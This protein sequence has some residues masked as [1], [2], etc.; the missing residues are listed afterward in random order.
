MSWTVAEIRELREGGYIVVDD[1]PCKI[2]SIQM[3]KPGKHGE[4][5]ARMDVMGLF[6]SRKRSI[7]H[8]V[9]HKVQVPMIDKRKGQIISISGDHAQIM[10]AENYSMMEL[11]LDEEWKPKV[12]A[13]Q[14]CMYM[15]VLG[16]VKLMQVSG[17]S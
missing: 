8:P 7:V 6:D 11:L 5:K 9:T 17:V 1:E 2:L 16:K 13:G 4:A 3:S 15:T 14:D 10:D 12:R